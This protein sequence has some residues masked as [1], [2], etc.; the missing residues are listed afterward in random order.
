MLSNKSNVSYLF[1]IKYFE[2]IYP[3]LNNSGG[4]PKFITALK[5]NDLKKFHAD[6]YHPSNAFTFSY[7]RLHPKEILTP[8]DNAIKQFAKREIASDVKHPIE[9]TESKLVTVEGPI[10][11]LYDEIKQYK[12]SLSWIV[13]DSSDLKSTYMWKVLS[14][15][16][17][18]GHSSPF[19]KA[20]IDTQ[21]GTDFSVNTGVDITPAKNIFT[22][23]LQ[24]MDET[25]IEVFKKTVADVLKDIVQNGIPK[26]RVDAIINQEELADKEVE[27]N[28][29]LSLVYRLYPRVFNDKNVL[30]S[31]DNEKVLSSFKDIVAK[32]PLVF[33]KMI[34]EYLIDNPVFEFKM[35]PSEY[36]EDYLVQEESERLDKAVGSLTEQE[37]DVIY[38][39]GLE[40]VE[41][42]EKKQDPSVLPSLS[43]DDIDR[44]GKTVSNQ[45]EFVRTPGS[46]VVLM[47]RQTVTR[48]L[49]YMSLMSDVT[50]KVPQ[51]LLPFLSLYIEGMKNVG[52][53]NYPMEELENAIKLNTGGINSSFL[54]TSDPT[55]KDDVKLNLVLSGSS[56][57]AKAP[58][59]FDLLKEM[60]LLPTLSNVGKLKPLITA[61]VSNSLN[62]LAE[63]GHSYAMNHSAASISLKRRLSEHLDGLS[64][65]QLLRQ[66]AEFTDDQLSTL[67]VPKLD[68][69]KNLVATQ[70][71][72]KSLIIQPQEDTLELKKTL[73]QEFISGLP[74]VESTSCLPNGPLEISH[75]HVQL[76]FQVAYIGVSI[77]GVSYDNKHGAA[78]Q[79]LSNILT[80]KYLHGEIREKGGAYGGGA[81][82][83]GVDGVFSFYSYRDPNPSN[84][85][86]V[87]QNA[88]GWVLNTLL[89]ERYLQ[90]AKLSIFQGIDAPIS[91]RNELNDKFFYMISDQL[92]QQRRQNLLN[93]TLDDLYEVTKLYLE[94]NLAGFKGAGATVLGPAKPAGWKSLD[95]DQEP[96]VYKF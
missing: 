26:E 91:P 65:I 40:L 62:A 69:I 46:P 85:L 42:Q 73:V 96:N 78:L 83:S 41:N 22:I 53:K 11:P 3:S 16:L 67:V 52:T 8:L 2:S 80:H 75:T 72:W 1:Y 54:L 36:F 25:N 74:V 10:D 14:H 18:D 89:T 63:T 76:P 94:P 33:Q 28:F 35:V 60:F 29:G 6:H 50:N 38:R 32:D 64:Q 48:G 15:L 9:L 59:V 12:V 27:S 58:K 61:S 55:N 57:D 31:L 23:G 34:A 71:Q 39:K 13:G 30:D 24:G 81:R 17:T 93:V 37:K 4:N 66:L 5:Y 79:I 68:E 87:V 90:E 45:E 43:T 88:P 20:L 51:S 95:F 86:E 7:G 70:G 92:K 77:P 19:H 44:Q 84:S 49:S 82:Y 47:S 21:I 56:L